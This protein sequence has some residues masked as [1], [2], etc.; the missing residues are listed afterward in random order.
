MK[1]YTVL[2][3]NAKWLSPLPKLVHTFDGLS[4][5]ISPFSP[6]L[7]DCP[8]RCGEPR[9]LQDRSAEQNGRGRRVL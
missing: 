5:G 4:E 2:P 8:A 3:E 9:D 6:A 7:Q 1:N